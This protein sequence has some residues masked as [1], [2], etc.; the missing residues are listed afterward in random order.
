[1]YQVTIIGGGLGGLTLSILLK[2]AGYAVLLI[3]K[4]SYP[5]HRV[6]GEYI[7]NESKSFLTTLLS[8]INFNDF[9]QI[10]NFQLSA[11]D[12]T[13]FQT[14]LSLGGFGISRYILDDELYKEALKLGVHIHTKETV[15]DVQKHHHIYEIET[16]H[17]K[18][19]SILV[20]GAFGKRANLD[21]KWKRNFTLIKPAIKNNFIG[22]KY[23]INYPFPSNSIALHNFKDGYCGIS[24]VENGKT[25]LCY[26][27][28]AKNLQKFNGNINKMEEGVLFKNPH[29]KKIFT[30]AQFLWDEPKTIAQINFHAKTCIENDILLIGDAAGLISP[31]SGNGMSIS[32]HSGLLVFELIDLFFNN[33]INKSDLYR[34]YDKKWKNCFSKRLATGRFVQQI[35]GQ[36]FLSL[37]LVHTLNLFPFL[38]NPLIQ[39]THGKEF[40]L[41]KQ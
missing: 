26:L 14:K 17:D 21:F 32:M 10:N 9:P 18:Y 15:L 36:P 39:S 30:T 19:Q 4:N 40:V 20:V 35:F 5:M 41:K 24:N 16:T 33:K 8:H 13:L 38:S 6:C 2:K 37:A 27:T 12:G 1:M 25:C 34:L 11:T 28:T 29:L 7:S 22:I 3:E 23:H 31:L